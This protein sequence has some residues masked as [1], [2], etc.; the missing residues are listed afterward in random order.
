[1]IVLGVGGG[2]AAFKAVALARELLRRGAKVRVVMTQSA[3][4]FV[5]PVTFTGIT[6]A[7]PVVDLWDPSYPGEIH[8]ELG[9]WAEAVVVAPATANLIARAA[10]GAADD[11]LTATLLCS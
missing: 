2:I 4:R 8:V 6:G 3:T 7:P 11:A 9:R 1:R 10:S 5:G